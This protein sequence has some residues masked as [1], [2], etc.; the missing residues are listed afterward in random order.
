[1]SDG[2]D[3]GVLLRLK[4]AARGYGFW[5]FTHAASVFQPGSSFEAN[6]RPPEWKMLPPPSGASGCISSRLVSGS[7]GFTSLGALSK[8]LRDC[9]S[10]QA[11]APGDNRSRR[12]PLLLSAW[13][14]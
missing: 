3:G 14:T 1:R 8:F 6:W 9:C 4:S 5:P 7:P 10:L 2:H 12:K 13:Q 11:L